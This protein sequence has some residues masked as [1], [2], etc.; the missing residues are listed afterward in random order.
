M[1]GY[2][3]NYEQATRSEKR[4]KGYALLIRLSL[5]AAPTCA[6]DNTHYLINWTSSGI[7]RIK[8]EAPYFT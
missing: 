7:G 4:S 3:L 8:K 2:A 1:S 6:V 5:F